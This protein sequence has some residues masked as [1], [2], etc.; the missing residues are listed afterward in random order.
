MS[1]LKPKPMSQKERFK[2]AVLLGIPFS[3]LMGI[4]HYYFYKFI[5]HIEFGITYIFVG[6]AIAWFI[7]YVSHGAQRKFKI[8]AAVGTLL[9]IVVSD[10]ILPSLLFQIDMMVQAQFL[11]SYLFSAKGIIALLI[12]VFG[13]VIAYQSL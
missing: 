12:R 10:I 9:S 13:V 11:L 2:R 3:I 7:Q 4:L 6:Y 1:F 5:G 8:L